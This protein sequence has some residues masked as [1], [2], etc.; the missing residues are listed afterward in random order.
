MLLFLYI[1]I[2]IT[3]RYSM[4]YMFIIGA[5]EEDL[6]RL[7]LVAWVL[8]VDKMDILALDRN[9]DTDLVLEVR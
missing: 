5:G 6:E 2:R 4:V 8:L 7:G 9:P 3:F 1:L